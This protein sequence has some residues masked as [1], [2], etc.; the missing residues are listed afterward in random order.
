MSFHPRQMAS[1]AEIERLLFFM[2]SVALHAEKTWAKD[3]ALSVSKQ[4]RRRNWTPS[5][6]QLSV[7]RGLV[8]DLFAHSSDDGGDLELIES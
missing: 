3:F 1:A 2:P 4:S 8:S 7:M 6:K 5:H